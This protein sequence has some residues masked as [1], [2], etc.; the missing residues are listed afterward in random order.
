MDLCK[1]RTKVDEGLNKVEDKL[2]QVESKLTIEVEDLG[3]LIG[4]REI[5]LEDRLREHGVQ[6]AT[7]E[8]A[9]EAFDDR[10]QRLG[11][12]NTEVDTRNALDGG[13]PVLGYRL[14]IEI[15]TL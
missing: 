15:D 9:R 10:L 12:L 4:H 1:V 5:A 3:S 2:Y 14:D 7:G 8:Q 6:I 13:P 11:Q